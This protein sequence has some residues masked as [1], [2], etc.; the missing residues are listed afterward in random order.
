MDKVNRIYPI[1]GSVGGWTMDRWD[2][3]LRAAIPKAD[4]HSS[5]KKMR[6]QRKAKKLSRRKNR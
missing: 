4:T 6:Q 2:N 5:S 3:G 1:Y